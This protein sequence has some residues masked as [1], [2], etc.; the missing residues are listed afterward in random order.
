MSK[1]D[2][3][4]RMKEIKRKMNAMDKRMKKFK[5]EIMLPVVAKTGHVQPSTFETPFYNN[6]N[7]K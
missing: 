4:K 1:P 7:K 3:K 6:V 2:H 5:E